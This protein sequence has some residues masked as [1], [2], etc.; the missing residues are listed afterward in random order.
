MMEQLQLGLG[1]R[2]ITP[3]IGSMLAGYAP[4]RPA[5]SV[6]DDVRVTAFALRYG[7]QTALLFSAEVCNFLLEIVAVIKQALVEATGVPAEHIFIACTHTHSSGHAPYD[8][9]EPNGFVRGIFIPRAIEAAREAL[10]AM[11]PVQMGI[12]TTYS[13][14]AINRRQIKEEDGRIKLGQNPWGSWDPT[15]TVVAFR[16]PD[17]TP[18][19]NIVHYGCHNTGSG[20]NSE[21]TRDWAGVMVDRL[22]EESGAVTAFI[23]GCGGDCGPRLPNGRTTGDLKMALEL[24]GKAAIDAV[25]AY[26]SIQLW[27]E[28][29]MQICTVPLELPLRDLGTAEDILAQMEAMGDPEALKGVKLGSYRQLKERYEYLKAGNIQPRQEAVDHIFLALGEL[30]LEGIPFEPFSLLTLRVKA[31]SPYRH[32]LCVGYTNGSRSYFP[33]VDQIVRGGYEVDMFRNRN[34]V[35]F[36]DDAEQAFVAGSLQ[37]I[38]AMH[39]K[40]R[41]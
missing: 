21:I 37:Q 16:S 5:L 26:R 30:L 8:F 20:K 24:G 13:E 35:P 33:S 27:E 14:V 6:N 11:G 12:G 18:V 28:A 34:L 38:R 32:T 3:P 29:P 22:E 40:N 15:M 19:A 36:A 7:Q 39:E 9:E 23:N 31:G 25:R 1:R 4:A 2:V 10:A 41:N 17:G